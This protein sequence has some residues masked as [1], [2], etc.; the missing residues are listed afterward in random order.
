MQQGLTETVQSGH[1]GEGYAHQHAVQHPQRQ[2]CQHR[3]SHGQTVAAGVPSG[4]QG[5]GIQR[6][7][8]RVNHYHGQHWPR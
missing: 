1:Q 7:Q 3:T 4:Q 8:Q 6:M 5:F 2:H